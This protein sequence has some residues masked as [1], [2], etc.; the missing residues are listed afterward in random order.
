[1]T[2]YQGLV[3]P[4]ISPDMELV[5]C[6]RK[7]AKSFGAQLKNF[8]KSQDFQDFCNLKKNG[9]HDGSLLWI[10]RSEYPLMMLEGV[11]GEIDF[12]FDVITGDVPYLYKATRFVNRADAGEKQISFSQ[13]YIVRQNGQGI[14]NAELIL[15]TEDWLKRSEVESAFSAFAGAQN[16]RL[17]GNIGIY[18]VKFRATD[19]HAW[20]SVAV[21][22]KGEG[23]ILACLLDS[24]R[25]VDLATNEAELQ[26]TPAY[27]IIKTKFNWFKYYD[28]ARLTRN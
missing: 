26:R 2:T 1:M 24:G 20:V 10:V 6:K 5:G 14:W 8:L 13:S 12:D 4:T 11:N 7:S 19:T 16:Y 23:R 9:I 18:E 15:K 3:V 25:I 17:V 22:D 21:S 27:S 28:E